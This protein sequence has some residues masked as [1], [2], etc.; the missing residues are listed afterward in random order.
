M[1]DTKVRNFIKVLTFN[2]VETI[3][4]FMIGLIFEIS[5]NIIILLMLVFFFTRLLIGQP[6]HYRRAYE[7]F[8]WSTLTFTSIFALTDLHIFVVILLTVFAGYI[9]TG[10]ADIE[11]LYMWKGNNSKYTDIIEHL[12]YHEL[13][14]KVIEFEE[15]LK[16]TDNI[17]YLLYKYKFKENF[18]FS[19]ISERL[20]MDNPRIVE[21]LDKIAF[22]IRIFC[23]I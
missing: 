23:G 10:R 2:I 11:E 21:K 13:D 8:I 4:I 15:K 17:L 1:K 6:K 16:K 22:S 12:K 19:E 3:V 9:A 5:K 20:D 14:D 7:C 18:T